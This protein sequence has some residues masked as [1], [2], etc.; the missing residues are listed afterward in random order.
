MN[1]SVCIDALYQRRNV[2]EGIRETKEAGIGA[3]E[4]WSWWD[5]DLGRIASERERLHLEVAAICTK[6][7]SLVDPSRHEVYLEGL[8]E[9]MEAA[10]RLGCRRLI[11]QVGADTGL[12]RKEQHQA[13]C[14]GAKRAAELLEGTDI[15]LL[16]EPLNTAVDHKGY[17]LSSSAEAFEIIEE[18]SR[19]G[20]T[21]LLVEQNAKKALSIA[22]RAYVLETGKVVLNGDAKDLLNDDSIKKAYLGE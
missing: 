6:F 4:L 14:Q 16:L 1:Y 3:I 7:A 2:L 20:T 19:G 17:Y 22:D 21:V 5:K 12:P 13:L 15:T 11:S 10:K 8:K 18:V 9:S